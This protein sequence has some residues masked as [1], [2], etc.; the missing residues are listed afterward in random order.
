MNKLN[1]FYILNEGNLS[2]IEGGSGFSLGLEILL[3]AYRHRKTI[4]KSF[5]KGFYN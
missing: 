4:E 5:N 1:D 2:Q 3:S